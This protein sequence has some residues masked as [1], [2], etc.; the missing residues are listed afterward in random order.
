M[1]Y[2]SSLAV[3]GNAD[4]IFNHGS[5]MHTNEADESPWWAVDLGKRIK[6]QEV[7]LTNRGDCCGAFSLIVFVVIAL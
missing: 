4:S 5:C 3:D 6:V 2:N 7:Y 1:S